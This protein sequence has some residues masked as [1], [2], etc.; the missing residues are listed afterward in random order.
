M[1]NLADLAQQACQSV[2][3]S[4]AD[5]T[6]NLSDENL[7]EVVTLYKR[8]N[9]TLVFS[10]DDLKGDKQEVLARLIVLFTNFKTAIDQAVS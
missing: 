9:N 10:N 1:L 6:T 7:Y 5:V 8:H 4:D 2:Y 3:G